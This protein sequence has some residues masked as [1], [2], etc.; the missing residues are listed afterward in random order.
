M[1]LAFNFVK[2]L[3]VFRW[4]KP[5]ERERS[6]VVLVIARKREIKK[7]KLQMLWQKFLA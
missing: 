4:L 7:L 5:V 2:L 3:M 6:L 1:L